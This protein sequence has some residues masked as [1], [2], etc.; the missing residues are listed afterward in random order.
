MNKK[1]ERKTK[2]LKVIYFDENSAMDYL[3]ISRGGNL[4]I[5]QE[6]QKKKEAQDQVDAKTGVSAKLNFLRIFSLNSELSGTSNYSKANED[7][8][9]STVTSTILTD[10]IEEANKDKENIRCFEEYNIEPVK[11]SMSF[12]KLC[13]PYMVLL[14]EK[15][16]SN[17]S[18]EIDFNKLDVLL[19]EVKGYYEFII[20]KGKEKAILRF[21][22]DS[23]RNNYKLSD[24]F[25]MDLT[26]YA[27]LVGH[28]KVE[29]LDVQKEMVFNT[30]E[31]TVDGVLND[32][33]NNL[34]IYDV[35]MAGVRNG[36]K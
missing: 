29:D 27:I 22:K 11:E 30:K 10:F 16:W 4:Q 26:Y 35:I 9:K 32:E 8:F 1:Q 5:I 18:D 34:E 33:D 2:I 6:M 13:T 12:Y 7:I 36:D 25:K 15:F 20:K 31:I 21:N 19:D 14:K 28:G 3:N 23:F 24:L 17:I